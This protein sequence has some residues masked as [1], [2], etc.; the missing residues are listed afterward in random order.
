MK[1]LN[2]KASFRIVCLCICLLLTPFVSVQAAGQ[3]MVKQVLFTNVNIFDGKTDKLAMGQD[4]LVEGNLIKQIG[5]GLK[6]NE[7]GQCH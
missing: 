7:G 5:K 1:S 3:A 2:T 4:V 6:A